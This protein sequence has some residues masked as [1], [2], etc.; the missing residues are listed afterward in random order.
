MSFSG[1][2]LHLAL[3]YLKGGSFDRKFIILSGLIPNFVSIALFEPEL[4]S[5]VV[6][7]TPE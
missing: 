2:E 7:Q 4:C 1:A 5:G 6:N 3:S